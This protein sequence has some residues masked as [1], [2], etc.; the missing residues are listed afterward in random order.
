MTTPIETVAVSRHFGDEVA[1]DRVSI[2]VE[3]GEVVGLLGANGAGKST[4]IRLILGLIRP[5]AGEIRLFGAAPRPETRRRVGYVPQGLGLYPD[6]TVG[7]NL[8]F[9]A[10][11]FGAAYRPPPGDLGEVEGRLVGSI[12]LGLRRRTAFAAALSHRPSLLV[13]DEPTSGVGP[14]ERS[15]LWDTIGE[16]AGSGAGVLVSTHHMEEAEEC[17]RVVMMSE[18]RVVASG[19]VTEIV[20]GLTATEITTP[21]WPEGLMA[22]E[23]GGLMPSLV[24]GR[25]RVTGVS[26]D[27]VK[28]ILDEAGI[29]AEIAQRPAGFE[30][31]FVGLSRR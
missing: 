20:G 26:L 21:R 6:L 30:E 12:S 27:Q 15:R 28:V 24:G 31:A 11:A 18:G 14:L 7:E 17:D 1:V 8:R 5:S 3:P 16:A 22:L 4:L 10:S 19:T 2:T 13:L 25:L 29:A 23:G 9:V